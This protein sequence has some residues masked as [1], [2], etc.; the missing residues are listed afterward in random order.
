[1]EEKELQEAAEQ[2]AEVMGCPVEEARSNLEALL[3]QLDSAGKRFSSALDLA[4]AALDKLGKAVEDLGETGPLY[5][6]IDLNRRHRS[7][8]NPLTRMALAASDIVVTSRRPAPQMPINERHGSLKRA[9][10]ASVSIPPRSE[11]RVK[12]NEACPC[13]SGVKFGKC[14][15]PRLKAR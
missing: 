15:L 4:N 7:T 9:V 2:V 14:C 10:P 1:M 11:G 3:P 5:S 13:G 12:R 6:P 8:L